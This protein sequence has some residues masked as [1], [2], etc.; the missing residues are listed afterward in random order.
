M[1][2]VTY[3]NPIDTVHGKIGKADNEY[4][5]V[6]NGK[7]FLVRMD[8]PRKKFTEK[9]Q[10]LHQ[11]FGQLSKLA[12]QIAK[13]PKKAAPYMEGFNAQKDKEGGQQ[14]VYQYIL[15]QLLR[16]AKADRAGKVA[17]LM[18]MLGE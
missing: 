9:E 16:E 7:R 4:Y 12:S 2:R 10:S 17:E 3:D 1:A 8:N 5:R 14:S 6:R 13:D 18:E 15:T 11:G